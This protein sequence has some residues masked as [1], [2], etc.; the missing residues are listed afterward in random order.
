MA[1]MAA[2]FVVPKGFC[3]TTQAHAHWRQT[4]EIEDEVRAE[5]S[6]WFRTLTGPLAVRSSSP[7]EDRADASFAGQ[8]QTILGVR[9]EEEFFAALKACWQSAQSASANSYARSK[10]WDGEIQMAVVVQELVP[11]TTAGVMFTMHPV[12]SR[13]DQ[14]VV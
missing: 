3:I 7:V 11:A 8:Y 14:V 1:L 13:V 6:S 9:T 4:G 12:S 2:G 5:L 10:G